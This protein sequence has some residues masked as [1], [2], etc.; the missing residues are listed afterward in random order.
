MNRLVYLGTGAAR[1]AG[2]RWVGAFLAAVL[3]TGCTVRPVPPT[4][5]PCAQVSADL[6]SWWQGEANASDVLGVNAA[7]LGNGVSFDA[8]MVGQGFRFDGVDGFA[9]ASGTGI[10]DLGQ[11][12]IEAWVKPSSLPADGAATFVALGDEKAALRYDG[13]GPGGQVL[14]FSMKLDGEL[15]HVLV[16]GVL[17]T[18]AFHHVAG[19]YDG[20]VMRLY[21]DGAQVGSQAVRGTSD[22]GDG[23]VFGSPAEPIDGL[24][25]EIAIYDRALAPSGIQAIY[26]AGPAGKCPVDDDHDGVSN[27]TDNCPSHANPD[28]AD[29][30]E[31]GRGDACE[32]EHVVVLDIDGLRPDVLSSYLASPD[33]EGGVLR[34]IT[35]R[36]IEAP[37][38]TTILPS[39]TFAAQASLFTGVY[40][41]KHGVTG[42]EWLDRTVADQEDRSRSYTATSVAAY[43][44]VVRVYGYGV[45]EGTQLARSD[46]S[47]RDGLANR[48]LQAKTLYEYA[49]EAGRRSVVSFNMFWKGLD[50]DAST[51]CGD[52]LAPQPQ[53]LWEWL[54]GNSHQYESSGSVRRLL[55]YLDTHEAPDIVTLY[56]PGLDH[57][58]HV[59]GI[60]EQA[61]YLQW[62]DKGFEQ[63]LGRL[64]EKLKEKGAY[65]NTV[66]IIVADHGQSDINGDDAHSIVLEER[67]DAE[68]EEVIQSEYDDIYDFYDEH[69]YDSFAGFNGGV[70]PIYLQNRGKAPGESAGWREGSG[71]KT[72]NFW[73]DVLPVVRAVNRHRCGSMV[74]GVA[75]P[76]ELCEAGE[77]A[78]EEVL[79]K[80]DSGPYQVIRP[81]SDT[82]DGQG[83]EEEFDPW[84]G[85]STGFVLCPL[86]MLESLH[87]QYVDPV[88]RIAGL[89]HNRSGDILLLPAYSKGYH[90]TGSGGKAE[91]GSLYPGDSYIPFIIAGKPLDRS[92]TVTGLS[93]IVDVVPTIADLLGF[94]EGIEDR[95]DGRS[96]LEPGFIATLSA[97]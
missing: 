3:L 41:S 46:E 62:Y 36:K 81:V 69:E 37:T 95:F 11:L 18:G 78:V 86:S 9:T 45:K 32:I 92:I 96:I 74:R 91:H 58:G 76:G 29:T 80:E 21:L 56:L 17:T 10:D 5:P 50:R 70:L 14:D 87:P 49:C 16:D 68:I 79:V 1:K 38:T 42:N 60:S 85:A 61:K 12:S 31:D 64:V 84:T 77:D 35:A 93:S 67:Y 54:V 25:D 40:P 94:Y 66:F 53:D 43:G 57:Q 73:T 55:D 88:R 47:Y 44:D 52:Y 20:S 34:E 33:S 22:P 27:I 39:V 48:D 82:P 75:E 72:P 8:G 13:Y 97:R 24:L 89:S 26:Q 90:F 51:P 63:P 15:Q 65:D 6:I 59:Q 4:Q 19:T 30:D 71:P 2:F 28:Q 23:V 7:T 83:C